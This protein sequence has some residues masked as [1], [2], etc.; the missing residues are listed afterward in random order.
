MQ[1]VLSSLEQQSFMYCERRLPSKAQRLGDGEF[2]WS[3]S[4]HAAGP[5]G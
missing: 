5:L 2:I 4:K 1:V 3:E